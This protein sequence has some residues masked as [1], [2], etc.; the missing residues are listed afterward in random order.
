MAR[1]L[2]TPDLKD[3]SKFLAQGDLFTEVSVVAGFCFLKDTCL[4]IGHEEVCR[5]DFLLNN[6][7]PE[8]IPSL[9]HRAVENIG[10]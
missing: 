5:C 10:L 1:G 7:G 6:V 9:A 4:S 2:R 3:S 8:Q